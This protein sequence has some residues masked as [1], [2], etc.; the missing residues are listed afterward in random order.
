MECSVC[1]DPV[2]NP[3]SAAE[4][5]FPL[6]A[7]GLDVSD[8]ICGTCST[9]LH[10]KHMPGPLSKWCLVTRNGSGEV[11]SVSAAHT[12]DELAELRQMHRIAGT[13]EKRMEEVSVSRARELKEQMTK[14]W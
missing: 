7:T 13:P 6:S 1:G 14:T 2:E 11:V 8:M 12:P 10:R 4:V 3:V 9:E 5:K